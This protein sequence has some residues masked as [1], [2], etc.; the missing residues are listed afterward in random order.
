MMKHECV[1]TL[2]ARSHG[3]VE[4]G[5]CNLKISAHV[6]NEPLRHEVVVVKNEGE[7]RDIDGACT[8]VRACVCVGGGKV[9][10]LVDWLL[11]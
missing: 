6:P 8:R 11:R 7:E 9:N 4:D 10:A 2:L 3:R 1:L 5:G